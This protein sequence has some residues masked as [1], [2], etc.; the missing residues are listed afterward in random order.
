[1]FKRRSIIVT[2]IVVFLVVSGAR[3]LW[4]SSPRQLMHSQQPG[5]NDFA[6]D[7]SCKSCHTTEHTEWQQSHHFMAMQ[8]ANDS[9]VLGDF[10]QKSFTADGVTSIFFKKDGKYFINTQGEDGNNRDYEVKYI[11]GFTLIQQY[12]VEFPG[13]CMPVP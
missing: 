12:L 8:P 7:Q 3:L 13:G 2:T 11:F 4:F 5:K 9:T 6:G 1:M 10:D